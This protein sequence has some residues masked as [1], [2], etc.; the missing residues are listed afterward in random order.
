MTDLNNS[1]RDR[2]IPLEDRALHPTPAHE[3]EATFPWLVI[4]DEE[5][6]GLSASILTDH[7]ELQA[8]NEGQAIRREVAARLR[9]M[10]DELEGGVRS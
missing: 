8:E 5:E 7:F 2:G 3:L 10:A 1:S 9:A 4:H 6:L